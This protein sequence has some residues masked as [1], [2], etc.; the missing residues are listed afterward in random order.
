MEEIFGTLNIT[1]LVHELKRTSLVFIRNK[2]SNKTKQNY[3]EI[4]LLSNISLSIRIMQ[5][6]YAEWY[7]LSRE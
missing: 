2:I 6:W 3:N 4:L 7:V 1:P 5:V